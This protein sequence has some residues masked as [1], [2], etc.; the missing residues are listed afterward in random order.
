MTSRVSIK[1]VLQDL[2]H[3]LLAT[4]CPVGKRKTCSFSLTIL[5][6]EHRTESAYLTQ[7]SASPELFL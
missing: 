3:G 4:M 6:S 2:W 1:V 5:S 7:V